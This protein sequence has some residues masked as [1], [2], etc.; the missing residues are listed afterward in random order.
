MSIATRSW[1]AFTL[2]SLSATTPAFADA[3]AVARAHSESFARACAAGDLK[4]VLALYED[5]AIAV[6]PGQGEEGVGKAAIEKMAANLCAGKGTSPVLKSVV[7]RPLGKGYVLTSGRWE[8]TAKA[9]DGTSAVTVI[10]TTEVLKETAGKWRYV[11]DHGSVG[12]PPPAAA[13]P[14]ARQP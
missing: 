9:P 11:L 5:D 1:I 7:G 14:A 6:W 10:R 12:L 8:L 2:L 3:T 4:A 13:A